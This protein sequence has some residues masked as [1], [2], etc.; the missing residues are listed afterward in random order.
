MSHLT[1]LPLK[2]PDFLVFLIAILLWRK[3]S[4]YLFQGKLFGGL[5]VVSLIILLG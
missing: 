3:A 4:S 5:I 2:L 1:L